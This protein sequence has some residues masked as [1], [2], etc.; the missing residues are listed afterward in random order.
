M[1]RHINCGR[2]PPKGRILLEKKDGMNELSAYL[3][4]NF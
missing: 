1:K 3:K 2:N 4:E